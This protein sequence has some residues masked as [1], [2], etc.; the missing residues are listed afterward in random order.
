MLISNLVYYV[1]FIIQIGINAFITV[2]HVGITNSYS[3]LL[4]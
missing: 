1:T 3:V 4:N 2:W